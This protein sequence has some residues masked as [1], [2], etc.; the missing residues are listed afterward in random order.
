M[1]S[2]SC[3]PQVEHSTSSAPQR[4][5]TGK[6][7][8]REAHTQSVYR[9]KKRLFQVAAVA[10]ELTGTQISILYG[11]GQV[12]EISRPFAPAAC[13]TAESPNGPRGRNFA[14]TP[15][16]RVG[17]HRNQPIITSVGQCDAGGGQVGPA[18]FCA[19]G[20]HIFSVYWSAGGRLFFEIV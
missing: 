3:V 4:R 2:G 19:A 10:H 11:T 8:D 12:V 5:I 16:L 1:Q 15:P 13:T 14:A 6:I 17:R 20:W 18:F 7:T 9:F